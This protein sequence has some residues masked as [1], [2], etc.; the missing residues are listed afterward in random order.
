MKVNFSD[1]QQ[2]QT[3]QSAFK[4]YH[5]NTC[6]RFVKRTSEKDYIKITG[7]STGCWS[8]VG[9]TGGAQ[10]VNL[11]RSG[12]MSKVGTPIH[13]LMH[14]VG[15]LHEQN[16]FDRDNHISV[17]YS[18]IQQGLEGN[19]DKGSSSSTTTFGVPYDYGSVMHYSANAFS[20]NGR[21]TIV[22]KVSIQLL[23]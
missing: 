6:I 7:D 4:A 23:Y 22:A 20:S 11:Q 8:S 17:M 13:E 21:P 19:F 12:C 9:R 3:L 15:F 2:L 5:D 14:A 16:R 18:N 1:S 10:V